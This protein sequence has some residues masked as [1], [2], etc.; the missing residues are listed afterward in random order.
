[1]KIKQRIINRLI[2]A[3][4]FMVAVLLGSCSSKGPI[5]DNKSESSNT[6][7][8]IFVDNQ[9][10]GSC[11]GNYSIANRDCSGNDGDAYPSINEGIQRLGTGN[12]IVIRGGTY[13]EWVKIERSGTLDAWLMIQAYPGETPIIDGGGSLPGSNSREGLVAISGKSYI[14]I[15][16]LTIRNSKYYGFQSY[17]SSH[18]RMTNCTV[19][20]TQDGGVIFN[21]GTDILIDSCEVHHTNQLGL[22]AYHEGI[23]I[24]TITS[25]E[26]KNT[27]IHHCGEEGIDAKVNST[28]GS[29]HHCLTHDNRGPNIYVD[30]ANNIDI[31]DNIV[32]A[33][34]GP[35]PGIVLGIEHWGGYPYKTHHINLYNNLIYDNGGGITFWVEDQ[36]ASSA[37]YSDITIVNNLLYKNDR[38]NVGGFH[39]LADCGN[40]DSNIVIS[41][42][43]FLDNKN[44]AITGKALDK[45]TIDHNLFDAADSAEHGNNAIV[46]TN[47]G[48]GVPGRQ[49]SGQ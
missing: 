12:K 8:T 32:Y 45:F 21:V 4:L 49:L 46:M 1:M 35:K 41:N 33:T 43:I 19:S 23:S 3:S 20:Y 34:T 40:I 48:V 31:Y 38:Q 37:K 30:Q 9:I 16:G 25:F 2:W 22:D 18:I 28:Q 27:H 13:V 11:K 17:Q 36:V 14:H 15:D 47:L 29:I 42:N 10:S 24:R 7:G 5:G 39:N 44:G 6:S 26:V